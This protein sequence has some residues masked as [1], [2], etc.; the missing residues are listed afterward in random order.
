M[1]IQRT[2]PLVLSALLLGAYAVSPVWAGDTGSGTSDQAS[3]Q[4][5]S[6]YSTFAGSQDNANALVAGLRSGSQITLTAADGTTTV[7]QPTTGA[8]G[9]GEVNISLALAQAELA[10]QGITAPTASQLEAA[11]NGGTV[12]LS[13][14]STADL[15]GILALRSGGEGWGQIAQAMGVN[16]G[17]IVSASHTDNSQAGLHG[18]DDRVS[19]D[20]NGSTGDSAEADADASANASA[21][22]NATE[23]LH[24][25]DRANANIAAHDTMGAVAP[26]VPQR[27]DVPDRPNIPDHPNVP[28]RPDLP[29]V[30]S[31]HVGG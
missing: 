6:Q 30:A 13:D 10:A 1:N 27:P 2:L 18:S 7:F 23:G 11:L 29:D 5:S 17:S 16:L 4:I 20:A 28:D 25:L 22:A 3:S 26:D 19:A 12:T 31:G 8:L 15:Q 21:T 9:Y 14:G 24:G